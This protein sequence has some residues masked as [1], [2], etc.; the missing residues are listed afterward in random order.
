MPQEFGST[1]I[2]VIMALRFSP[3]GTTMGFPSAYNT[4]FKAG[5]LDTFERL[6]S[7]ML[8]FYL[9]Y[10][11]RIGGERD[12]I[13]FVVPSPGFMTTLKEYHDLVRSNEDIYELHIDLC[14]ALKEFAWDDYGFQRFMFTSEWRDLVRQTFQENPNGDVGLSVTVMLQLL[15]QHGDTEKLLRRY[16]HNLACDG[17][18]CCPIDEHHYQ[19]VTQAGA[20]IEGLQYVVVQIFEENPGLSVVE[21]LEKLQGHGAMEKL[22]REYIKDLINE[23]YLYSTIDDDHYTFLE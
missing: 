13:G 19:A 3:P 10:R 15:V 23:G 17:Y 2:H 8:T 1:A 21:V 4:L 9:E 7:V 12:E 20:G 6:D 11:A 18:L 22:V 5:D 16:L 14:G